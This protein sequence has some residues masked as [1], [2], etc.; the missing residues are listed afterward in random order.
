M[1]YLNLAERL[2][3]TINQY[4]CN[5]M[6]DLKQKILQFPVGSTFD[7]AWDFTAADRDEILEIGTFLRSHGYRVGNTHEWTFLRPDPPE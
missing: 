6:K 3:Y 1:E 4:G 5:T 7:F 2:H